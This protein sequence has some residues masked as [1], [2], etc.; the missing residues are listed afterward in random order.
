MKFYLL[1]FSLGYF[2]APGKCAGQEV[3]KS[4]FIFFQNDHALKGDIKARSW[5]ITPQTIFFRGKNQQEFVEYMTDNVKWYT[6]D[7]DHYVRAEVWID[8]RPVNYELD[9]D[10]MLPEN[11]NRLEKD[12]VFLKCLVLGS[13]YDLL[14]LIDI[15]KSHYYLRDSAGNI[16]QLEYKVFLNSRGNI[17]ISYG[18]RETLRKINRKEKNDPV[19][20]IA[21]QEGNYSAFSLSKIVEAINNSAG[22]VNYKYPGESKRKKTSFFIGGAGGATVTRSKGNPYLTTGI[23]SIAGMIGGFDLSMGY[24]C[25]GGES[26][27]RFDVLIA[28]MVYAANSSYPEK[29]RLHESLQYCIVPSMQ[30]RLPLFTLENLQSH[31]GGGFKTPIHLSEQDMINR[32]KY[33]SSD[34]KHPWVAIT[35]GG[36]LDFQIRKKWEIGAAAY[37]APSVDFS[38]NYYE[39]I[40]YYTWI[41]YR[42]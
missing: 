12:T 4:G 18:F 23:G 9:P 31:I 34:D 2:L 13:K 30:I 11:S 33:S 8:H 27:F 28:R 41:A 22:K 20:E 25:N 15:S 6:A 35:V 21:I 42:F 14:E 19:I 24:S 17:S 39:P 38:D 40:H 5:H 32:W 16:M 10:D 37:Q 29:Q 7:D 1:F 3:I 36:Q 26:F